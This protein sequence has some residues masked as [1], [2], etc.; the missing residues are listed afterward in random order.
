MKLNDMVCVHYF[1][2]SK[3]TD[4]LFPF[5]DLVLVFYSVITSH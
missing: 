4:K 5:P 2:C 3:Y 1:Q